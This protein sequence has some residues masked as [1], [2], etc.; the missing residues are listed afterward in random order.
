MNQC[1]SVGTTQAGWVPGSGACARRPS[2][3]ATWPGC[4]A[5]CWT[6]STSAWRCWRPSAAELA[7]DVVESTEV[8]AARVLAAR[9]RAARRY[10]GT[11]YRLNGDVP[12]PVLRRRFPL[13]GDVALPVEQALSRGLLSARGADRVVRVAWTVADLAGHD[14]PTL[15]DVGMALACREPGT[16]WA[17]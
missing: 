11:P 13:T 8:V 3:G 9:E 4:R 14:R 6:V 5:R 7:D 1:P 12:G 2:A 17:A 16:A 10:A 15:S